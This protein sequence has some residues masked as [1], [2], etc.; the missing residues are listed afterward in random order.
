MNIYL[1]FL[2]LFVNDYLKVVKA[3]T[4]INH[5]HLKVLAYLCLAHIVHEDEIGILNDLHGNTIEFIVNNVKESFKK[6][7][8][9]YRGI[10][11]REYLAGLSKLA[12]NRENKF[13]VCFFIN[14]EF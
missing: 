8:H 7:D 12:I 9:R 14:L 10:A 3:F 1:R 13:K 2:L 6:D 4:Q 11:S 5:D